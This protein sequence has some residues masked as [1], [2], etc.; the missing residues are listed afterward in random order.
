M[1]KQLEKTLNMKRK[2][3]LGFPMTKGAVF[4]GPFFC[5][6]IYSGRYWGPLLFLP[7]G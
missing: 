2:Q 5:I 4:G 1:E 3:G 6:V 7:F